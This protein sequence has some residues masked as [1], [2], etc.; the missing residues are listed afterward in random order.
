MKQVVINNPVLNSPFSE[1]KKHFYFDNEGITNTII[2][3]RRNSSY[4]V[5]IPSPKKVAAKLDEE[6]ITMFQDGL[7]DTF[8][9]TEH[10]FINTIREKVNKWRQG[11]YV[12]VT[13]TTLRLLEYWNNA[14]REKKL[15]FCQKEAVETLIYIVEVAKRYNDKFIDEKLRKEQ[16][17]VNSSL[18]R[19]AFKMAT[20]TGKTVVIAMIIA[21]QTLNKLN[22]PFD[23]RFTSSF[24][25]VTPGITIRD[26]LRVILPNDK[27]N[28]YLERDILPL[29]LWENLNKAKIV[30]TN[31]HNFMLKDKSDASK[32]A[33]IMSGQSENGYIKEM[34][35]EMVHRVCRDFGNA[36]NIMVINDEA[37]HCYH[38]KPNTDE[39]I[40]DVEEKDEVNRRNQEAKIWFNGLEHINKTIGIKSV[41]DLSA[42]PF[43]L[44]GSG[45]SEGKLFPWV[46]SDFSLIDAIE[47]GIVKVPRVP[48]SDNSLVGEHLT[49][50]N[51]WINIKDDLP[52]KG[53]KQNIISGEP[54]LPVKLE[55]ALLSLYGNYKQYY[56]EWQKSLENDSSTF[57]PPAF[58]VVC[59][60]TT[61]SK[62]VYD[63][64]SGWEKRLKN[65]GSI[66]V[67]GQLP[68]FSNEEAGQWSST[69][70][71]ILVDSEQ[72]ETGESLSLEFKEVAKHQIEEFKKEYKLRFPGR[73]V[74]KVTDEE[75]LREVMN[76][77]GKR[78]KLG[79][80]VKCI[81][82]VSM[83]TEGWD[84]NNVTHIL[85]VRAFRSQLL[86]EQ[87]VGRAL[88]RTNYIPNE[89][90]MFDPEY[91]EVYGVPFSFIP[92]NGVINKP[93]I[94]RK[95]T[96]VYTVE[97]RDS[98]IIEFPKLAGYRYN[99][100]DKRLS[101]NF[102]EHSIM[103]LTT[104]DLP[105]TTENAPIV[106]ESSIH[107]LK[108]LADRRLQE[109]IFK[110]AKLILEKYFEEDIEDRKH[111]LFPQLLQ[112]T[113]KWLNECLVCK[114]N[115]F[116]QLLLLTELAHR[117]VDRIYLS[118]VSSEKG[119]KL[120]LPILKPY[121]SWGSTKGVDFFTSKPVYITDPN[122]C[123]ITHVVADTNSWEQKMAQTLEEMPEVISYVKNQNLGFTI[124]YTINGLSK[125]YIP[126]FIAKFLINDKVLNLIIE[127][128]G[129]KKD[130]KKIK[131]A[132]AKE[133]WVPSVNNYK[134]F[135]QWGFIEI[136]D[137]WGQPKN[138]IRNLISQLAGSIHY[139]G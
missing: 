15:F 127:V 40:E 12:G 124:P 136:E 56:D 19:I 123:H 76:T 27:E 101:I 48:V 17:I 60:N 26:R 65:G 106:G 79:E 116:P 81:V 75:L 35:E 54:K 135:G 129:Y 77:V 89:K 137:P 74:N 13:R 20:G 104:L 107:N 111:W 52:R 71:T 25:V 37:H 46:V 11:G 119:D 114:D 126:D 9:Q 94:V 108:D 67:P 34:P 69:L 139:G 57:S 98:C 16:E 100:P 70:N 138:E 4:F 82:S 10:T 61:V 24:L 44:K 95:Q 103:V 22:N 80:S 96:H 43:F 39:D 18:Y 110:L 3:S 62:L 55:A 68:I 99:L 85:G 49:Y 125:N 122:K 118:I 28:Y 42:T 120:L 121:E 38:S 47:S 133:L 41:V 7:L 105:T 21:W 90:D 72:L 113:K 31:Y 93:T 23:S 58:I 2:K 8:V 131:V 45:Y 5:P 29:E 132:T 78:G 91:A 14:H 134:Q 6:Q 112:I 36:K 88:R 109:I 73:D 130:D 115:T 117:A 50:R 1:P 59:N 83:L 66:V 32:L 63:Y 87:V 92:T 86:C 102:N 30:I 64:I 51:L 97:E 128:T 33:K 84:A 53:R